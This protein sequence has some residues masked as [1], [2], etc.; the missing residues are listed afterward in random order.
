MYKSISRRAFHSALLS[1]PF[2]LCARPSSREARI[3]IDTE[4]IIGQIDP[5]IYGNFTEHLGRCIEGG[6]FEENSPLSDKNGFRKDVLKAVEDLHVTLLRWP[7]GNFS[8]NYHWRDGIGPRDE[9]PARLEMAWGTVE[10]NRFG[11]H[12][13]LDYCDAI[14]TEPYFC[15]NFGTGSWDE[16]QQWVEYCNVPGGTA[17]SNL[18]QKNG[19]QEPWKV[20]YWSLGNEMD[21]PWQ[22][23]HRTA[24]DYGKFA[25][26]GAKL[27]KWTDPNIKLVAAGSSNFGPNADWIGWNRTVLDYLKHHADY[28]SLHLYVGNKANDFP[29]FLAS[30]LE[31][32]DRIKIAEGII[33]AAMSGT[34][35]RKL[36]IAWDEWNVWYRA[37]GESKER[38]REILE[39]HYN[40]EDA[41]VVATFLNAFVNNAHVV[42]IANMAQLV[43]V[44]APIFTSKTGL[45]LQT[46]YYPLQLFASNSFGD[47]LELFVDAPTYTSKQSAATPLLDV[48]AAHDRGTIVMNVVNRSRDETIPAVFELEDQQFARNFEAA[49]VNGPDIKSENNFGS[50]L[51]KITRKQID[52]SGRRL[53]YEFPPHSFTMLKG[54]LS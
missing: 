31:L 18:R 45:Y 9:R 53:R 38:G 43:N 50:E 8:S 37:R 12:E 42:K 39:E 21:G 7:G 4:R 20:K 6:I 17:T 26:E 3:K 40:L 27:M 49:E 10:D 24:E 54:K 28:L 47:A 51:V 23:G 35:N 19:R 32:N 33:R 14:K 41:L 11:T 13:F 36:Y 48:S 5:K 34:D 1:A 46:I 16:A 30:S 22:M 15:A 25:L 29:E 52:A 2:V 44:I